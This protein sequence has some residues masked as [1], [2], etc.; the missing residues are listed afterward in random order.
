MPS[1]LMVIAPSEFRDEEYAH[2]KEVL[3][4][5]GATVDTASVAPG[6]CRGRF[7]MMARA[8]LAVRDLDP[9][10]YDAVLFIGGAGSKVFFDDEDAHRIA[11]SLAGEGKVI[12]A[13]CIAPSTLARAG[14]LDGKTVTSFPS[15]E[16]DLRSHGANFTGNPV[17]VDGMF[18]TASGPEAAYDFG[19]AVADLL[20]MP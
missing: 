14:L 17:E 3:E 5:R 16:G 4:R 19:E 11:I 2:P 10:G 7:G 13:I 12:G 15:Q 20:G 1:V 8:E 6:P 9:S 18:V